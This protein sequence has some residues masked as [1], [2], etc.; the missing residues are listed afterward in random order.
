V[1]KNEVVALL[2]AVLN[3][4]GVPKNVKSSIE[5]IVRILGNP[6]ADNLKIAETISILDEIGTDPNLSIYTRTVIWDAMSKLEA[7]K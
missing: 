3:D 6:K 4:R 7:L 1:G 2:S 5:Q